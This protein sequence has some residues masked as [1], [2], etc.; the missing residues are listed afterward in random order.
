MGRHVLGDLCLCGG[1]G[2]LEARDWSPRWW[3]VWRQWV[4]ATLGLVYHAD[5]VSVTLW[6]RNG[7]GGGAGGTASGAG[8]AGADTY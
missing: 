3:D 1:W 4:W 8:A 2:G 7:T 6:V 5:A